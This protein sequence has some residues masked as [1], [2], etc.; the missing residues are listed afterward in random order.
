M[1]APIRQREASPG[2]QPSAKGDS[3]S[4][5]SLIEVLVSLAVF[6]FGALGVLGMVT[7]SLNMNASARTN[8]EATMIG[9]WKMEQFQ[10]VVPAVTAAAGAYQ[11]SQPWT[12]ANGSVITMSAG[13]L[14]G[15]AAGGNQYQV[16]WMTDVP[17]TGLRH[18]TVE[19][20]WPRRRQLQGLNETQVAQGFIDCTAAGNGCRR[21]TFHTYR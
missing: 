2:G 4:G 16:R 1:N 3:E 17:S 11:W 7:T 14:A 21:L 15:T 10:T 9:T 18:Y 5:M 19:V 6:S 20:A 12:M 8:T 13:D